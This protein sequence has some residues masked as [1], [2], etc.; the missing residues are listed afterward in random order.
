MTQAH[1]VEWEIL[2]LPYAGQEY[3]GVELSITVNVNE[4][5]TPGG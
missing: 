4:P 3:T 2:V 5:W 1:V